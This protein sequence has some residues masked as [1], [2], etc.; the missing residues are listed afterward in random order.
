MAG[1]RR[2]WLSVTMPAASSTRARIAIRSGDLA[3]RLKLAQG[4]QPAAPGASF[5]A[6]WAIAQTRSQ[7]MVA[8][9]AKSA[10]ATD[11]TPCD[12]IGWRQR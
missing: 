4:A 2:G 3:A 7:G 11:S 1:A 9:A 12:L 6:S 5:A 10:P 8:P